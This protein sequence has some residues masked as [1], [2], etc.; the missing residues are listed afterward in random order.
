[1][2]HEQSTDQVTLDITI[3]DVIPHKD[4]QRSNGNNIV[5]SLNNEIRNI[6]NRSYDP[7]E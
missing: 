3:N 7:H 2:E 4:N 6:D 5:V 1:M